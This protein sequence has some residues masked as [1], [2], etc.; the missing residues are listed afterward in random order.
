M[1]KFKLDKIGEEFLRQLQVEAE[2]SNPVRLLLTIGHAS[3]LPEENLKET[4]QLTFERF[5][6]Y[7]VEEL[8]CCPCCGESFPPS[9]GGCRFCSWTKEGR[10][11]YFEYFNMIGKFQG[12]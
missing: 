8:S 7:I 6:D 1:S 12:R 4:L 5:Y 9:E 3:V 11:E 10:E 2:E